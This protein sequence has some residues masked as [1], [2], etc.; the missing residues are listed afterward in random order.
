MFK[1]GYYAL[2][3]NC[4]IIEYNVLYSL[5]LVYNISY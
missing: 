5:E 1:T 3:F 2:E 4:S